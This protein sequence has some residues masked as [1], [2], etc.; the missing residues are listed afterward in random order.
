[1]NRPSP[2]LHYG[3][4]LFAVA[5]AM[6]LR[7]PLWSVLQ[8]E[9]AFLFLWPVVI[10]CAWYGGLGPGLLATLLSALSAAFFLL[11]PR[12][13]LAAAGP[14][15][16]VGLAVFV[17]VNV[18]V[19]F[20]CEKL[21]RSRRHAER[22]A[23]EV[24]RQREWLRV[25]LASIG[26]AVIACDTGG[27]VTFLNPVARTL[28]GWDLAEAQGRPLE[29]VFRILNE[30]TRQPV[31]PPVARVLREGTVVGLANHTVLVARDDT[32][33]PIEDS[34]A[35][36]RN[37]RGDLFGVI[38]VFRDVSARR[39]AQRAL[40]ERRREETARLHFRALFESSPG[41]FLVLKPDLTLVA[42]SDAYL[43]A[44]MT[45]REDIVGR[46]LFDVFPDNPDDPAA[47]GVRN[48][49][50]SLDRVR[51]TRAADAMAVQKYDIRRPES[52]GG[53]FEERYW[54]PVNSP[55]L[56]V[57]GEVA[58]LIHRV[59]DVTEF[60]RRK[61]TSTERA[62]DA[63]ESRTRMDRVEAEI[64]LRGQQLQQLNELL[65][66]ANEALAAEVAE[67][68]RRE[69]ALRQSEERFRL[70]VEGTTDYALFMLDPQGRVASWNAGAER[71]K[72]Y[73]AEEIVGQH[74]SRFYPQE[75]LD[76]GWPAEELRRAAAG[77][78]FE[79][80]GW[81]VRK[82]GSTFWADVVITALKDQAGRLRGFSKLTRD[83]T[84]RRQREEELLQLHRDLERRVQERTAALAASNEALQAEIAE[85]RRAEEALREA[86]RR[87]DQFVMML[88]HEL[89][90]P[91]APIRNSLQVLQA[92]EADRQVVEQARRVMARQVGHMAHIIEDLLDVSRLMRG[93]VELRP[94]RIDLA[95]LTRDALEDQRP[96]FDRSG[97]ALEA[98]LPEVPV[99]VNADATRLTQVFDNLLQNA[100][101]FTER[102]GTVAVRVGA[103]ADRQHAVWT[104][105]DTGVGIDP[106]LL[107]RLFE[108]FAQADRSLDRSQGGL[109]LGLALVKGLVELHGGEVQAASGGPGRGAEFVVRL[110]VQPEP[111]AITAMPEGPGRA[112][113]KLRIL[114]VEDNRDAADSLKVL[115]ELYGYDVAVAYTGPA[116]VK[117]AKGWTPDVVLCDIGLP[118]LDGYG[119]VR[120]LRRDPATARARM[121]AVTGYGSESDRER[122]QE[123]GFDAHL[124][125]P[126]DPATL[127][128]LLAAS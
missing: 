31:T 55:V 107:P 93:R 53:G 74:F 64:F 109:G 39:A 73:R 110:P 66:A 79:N 61:Q 91:L 8:G 24:A 30:Q 62:A 15:E 56:G 16:L 105:R 115:L 58:Y 82:D 47:T 35:P 34:A 37:G 88:A 95:R 84:E 103:D 36:I 52:A 7:W 65:R 9:L 51:R 81:R 12:F 89:R 20:L 63:D 117:A 54:S 87:K 1:M 83:L 5:A 60:V 48:L 68:R 86:D 119:V 6:L 44:T 102:G 14:A 113:K 46:G 42:V 28:T 10:L 111:A 76:R 32:E 19:S 21:H 25:S 67:R 80:E 116:G 94:E 18:A 77:G 29:D 2:L 90:N 26:D 4:S 100:V 106:D 118:G 38:L 85:R 99:W 23:E 72:G 127:Q 98:D 71:I 128:E 59:E 121:I 108:P 45:K 43:A 104:I 69:E 96:A 97:L 70:L 122:S 50:A 123:A 126:A 75:A 11:E 78:R 125:K 101:K 22:Q 40:E 13:S 17:S 33:R 57:D 3:V 92:S 27:R 41:L 114:V 124:T 120:E 112:G 49:R